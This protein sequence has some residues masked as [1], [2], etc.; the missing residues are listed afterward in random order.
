MITVSGMSS[1]SVRDAQQAQFIDS[2]RMNH[3]VKHRIASV[4]VEVDIVVQ[5]PTARYPNIGS[6]PLNLFHRDGLVTNLLRSP[7]AQDSNLED[8]PNVGDSGDVV[9]FGN[10]GAIHG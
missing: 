2:F 6:P 9:Q 5:L 4:D 7:V 10:R 3:A 1:T 8:R